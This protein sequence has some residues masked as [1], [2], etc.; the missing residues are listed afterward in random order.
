M[1]CPVATSGSLLCISVHTCMRMACLSLDMYKQSSDSQTQRVFTGAVFLPS[2]FTFYFLLPL[3]LSLF[4]S[5]ASASAGKCRHRGLLPSHHLPTSL[6]TAAVVPVHCHCP[7][8]VQFVAMPCHFGSGRRPGTSSSLATCSSIRPAA[9]SRPV[10]QSTPD[11]EYC[12]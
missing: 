3:S 9:V 10:S 5:A 12:P 2:P 7:Y 11:R 8:T 4:L 6:N 1:T